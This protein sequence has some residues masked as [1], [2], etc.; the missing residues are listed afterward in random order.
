[1]RTIVFG[2][3]RTVVELLLQYS[4]EYLRKMSPKSVEL[5]KAYRGGYVKEDR[6][7]IEKEL[8][9]GKL[10]GVIATNALELGVD[11]GEKRIYIVLLSNI[12]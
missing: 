11:I 2:K 3:V 5:V 4:T 12:R 6:R 9:A 10:Q 7:E 1:M 8:F